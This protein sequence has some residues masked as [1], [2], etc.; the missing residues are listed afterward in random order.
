M[1]MIYDK[2]PKADRDRAL[3]IVS[4]RRMCRAF[5]V[6]RAQRATAEQLA[7]MPNSVL[8]RMTKGMYNTAPLKKALRL[9]RK[10]GVAPKMPSKW[11]K[12][13]NAVRN[14]FVTLNYVVKRRALKPATRNIEVVKKEA[15][16]A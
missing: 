2:G 13:K 10:L 14:V 3:L 7:R 16:H 15:E 12:V 8:Y 11:L 1:S 4:Y 9:A 6:P 5:R